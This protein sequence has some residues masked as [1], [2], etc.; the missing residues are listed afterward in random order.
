M[1]ELS[2]TTDSS[3]PSLLGGEIEMAFSVSL[4][5]R[6]GEA[7]ELR[8]MK[9]QSRQRAARGVQGPATELEK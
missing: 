1:T 5:L 4:K 9:R 6:D 8:R 3:F 2:S 7:L